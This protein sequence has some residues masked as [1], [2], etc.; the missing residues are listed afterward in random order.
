MLSPQ[1]GKV[2]FR[3]A[4]FMAFVSAGLIF[5]VKPGSAEFVAT[6]ITLAIGIVFCVLIIVVVRHQSR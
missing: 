2:A 4:F 6:A 3:I 1:I 5:F